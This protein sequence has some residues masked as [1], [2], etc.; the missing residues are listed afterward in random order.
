MKKET[1]DKINNKLNEI[2]CLLENG[3]IEKLE[4]KNKRASKKISE[5]Q[6]EMKCMKEEHSKMQSKY[7]KKLNMLEQY[8]NDLERKLYKPR[9]NISQ[10]CRMVT[11]TRE[12]YER[13]YDEIERQISRSGYN[14]LNS[15]S[16][17]PISP[18]KCE[19]SRLKCE[20]KQVKEEKCSLIEKIARLNVENAKLKANQKT[21]IRKYL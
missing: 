21:G 4:T 5:L 11:M 20:L 2:V 16:H 1:Q 7:Q 18:D 6:H 15:G 9:A 14:I 17:E 8:N 10:D 12:E 19:I 3:E 13:L